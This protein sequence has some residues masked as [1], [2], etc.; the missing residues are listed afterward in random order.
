MTITTSRIGSI[1][2][3]DKKP[4]EGAPLNNN[5]WFVSSK[6][7][8]STYVFLVILLHFLLLSM[9][10]LNTSQAW[11]LTNLVHAVVSTSLKNEKHEMKM[12][13]FLLETAVFKAKISY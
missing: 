5:L 11:T 6:E 13:V 12:G 10:F 7:A 3:V 9:P 1:R 4:R 2:P 8:R